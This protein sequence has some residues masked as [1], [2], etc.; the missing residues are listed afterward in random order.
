MSRPRTHLV[1]L[2]ALLGLV[3]LGP[4]VALAAAPTPAPT[5]AAPRATFGIQPAGAKGPDNRPYLI[6]PVAP[7]A[8]VQDHV[9]VVNYSSQPL[10]LRVYATDAFNGADG[11]FSL[12]DRKK[13]ATQAGT[14]LRTA[15]PGASEFLTVPKQTYRIVPVTLRVPRGASPGDHVAGIVASLATTSQ[16]K[17]GTAVELDQRV[18]IRTFVRVSGE[19]T[20]QLTIEKVK[21]SYHGVLNPFG[22][23]RTTVDYTVRNTGNVSLGGAQRVRVSGLLGPTFT[24][25]TLAD[26]PLLLPGGSVRV[27]ETVRHTW[28]LFWMKANVEISPAVVNGVASGDTRN[29]GNT[30]HFLAVPWTLLASIA[31]L[32]VANEV[33]RRRR[34]KAPPTDRGKHAR[35]RRTPSAPTTA[36][37]PASL[38]SR[39]VAAFAV[40]VVA[41]VAAP[42]AAQAADLPYKDPAVT[43]IIGLCDV[44]GHNVT[45]GRTTDKPFFW[46]AV[47][48]T[49]ASA[50]YETPGGTAFL[51]AYQP[52]QGVDPGAWSGYG[53]AASARYSNPR[54]PMS[55]ATPISSPLT[56]FLDR[57][58][59]QWE[60]LV[61]LRLILGGTNRSPRI[62]SYDATDI[63]VKDGTWR[64]VRGGTAPCNDGKAVSVSVLLKVPGAA[65]TPKPGAQSVG[66]VGPAGPATAGSSS[67]PAAPGSDGST[68]QPDVK[69]AASRTGT[70]IAGASL[71]PLVA[72]AGGVAVL[73][74]GIALWARRRRDLGR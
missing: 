23:G 43:G 45:S 66:P 42:T 29:D 35:P 7:G 38:V 63:V 36:L 4:A 54:H 74:V 53:L 28:P 60:G 21:R 70:G 62:D 52:R 57:Y 65:G 2:L 1:V 27:S 3:V 49:A 15:V 13:P 46:R 30:G 39:V 59:P 44:N 16:G 6:Y 8:V 61:Q 55:Q 56:S 31:F 40:V 11:T 10:T 37:E 68:A 73:G 20:P 69:Q 41:L 26:L 33:R 9:A 5:P 64:V 25:D 24:G 58:P 14:W 50:G 47:G 34:R 32:V 18:G 67:T 48:S 19:L 71:G 72:A 12:L 22:S 51:A 17:Q